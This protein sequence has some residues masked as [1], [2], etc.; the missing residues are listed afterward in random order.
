MVSIFFQSLLIG[1]SGA[2]MPGSLLT[3]TIDRSIKSGAKSGPLVIVGH[4]LL[5]LVIVILIF[6]GAGRILA[7]DTAQ[8][9]IGFAG[10]L[11]L[12][13]MGIGMVKDALQNKI[14]INTEA[15]A[16]RGNGSMIAA[17]AL[18]SAANPYFIFWWAV[19]GLGLIL[20]AYKAFGVLGV[21]LFYLGHTL[22]DLSWYSLV[23]FLISRTRRFINLKIYKMV[24]ILLGLCLCG[25]GINFIIGS[26]KYV[27]K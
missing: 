27:V 16:G 21:I 7:T 3:Y 11:A 20:S 10:G 22:A 14:T 8:M 23:A 6:A 26:L 9:I 17:G 4:S 18:I 5:E 12:N 1:Y 13:L 15:V 24:I 19:I 25:F 2:L